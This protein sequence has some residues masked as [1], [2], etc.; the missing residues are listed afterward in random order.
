MKTILLSMFLFAGLY[1]YAQTPTIGYTYDAG[2]NRTSRY[3]VSIGSHVS[4]FNGSSE[5]PVA[6]VNEGLQ[7]ISIYPNPT[8]G[9]FAIGIANLDKSKENYLVLYDMQ[10]KQLKRQ[11]IIAERTSVDITWNS[12]GMYLLDIYLGGVSSH[13]KIVKQ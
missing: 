3:V 1:G 12:V 9:I 13:W 11:L 5:Q 8:N 10:G 6:Q 7:T 2:G 4:A